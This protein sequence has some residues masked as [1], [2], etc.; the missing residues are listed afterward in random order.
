M[1]VFKK[2]AAFFAVTAAF[3][4]GALTVSAQTGPP[5]QEKL[6]NGMKVLM[7]NDPKA[8]K[9]SLRIRVHAGSAFDPQGREGLMQMLADIM[10]PNAAAR[11][12]FAED[13]GGSLEVKTN[14][15][16]IE[17]NASS[18]PGSFLTMLETVST[19]VSNPSIDNETTAAVKTA[20]LKRLE[21]LESDPSYVA[22]AAVAGR[23]F[24]TFPYGRP[25][26][27][28]SKSVAK[29]G[30]A[31]LI[32]GRQRFLTADNATLA[33]T[34]N[35]DRA[36]GFRAI[37][38]Y[39]GSWLKSDRKTPSTFKQPDDPPS[40]TLTIASP[41][42]RHSSVRFA[43]R[44]PSR[45]DKEL[46]PALVFAAILEGKIKSRVTDAESVFGRI[47]SHVLPGSIIVGY[48]APDNATGDQKTIQSSI[49]LISKAMAEPVTEAE[50]AAAKQAV[51]SEW[52]KKN[53][54]TFWLDADTYKIASPAADI[55]AIEAVTFAE[56]RA[57]ADRARQKPAASVIINASRTSV[58]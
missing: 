47:D 4:L 7:W 20:L 28:T 48:S 18:V 57:F 58:S 12:F 38:R 9:V 21:A 49:D 8:D 40:S 16:Y 33:V 10:F 36:L 11:E 44:G 52:N 26:L 17:I 46:G 13:L 1:N 22:D 15:D 34:G 35:F 54:P 27:G 41:Q 45:S 42:A 31:D 19:A 25:Q 6:L 24:G 30:F 39:F 37:R 51:Q 23:L 56:V 29:I 50:F 3:W 43:F 5:Q 32:E 53:V 55:R 2:N 14:Y